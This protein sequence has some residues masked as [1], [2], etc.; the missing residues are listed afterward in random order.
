[1]GIFSRRRERARD[2]PRHTAPG[3]L[4]YMGGRLADWQANRSESI[5][6]AGARLANTLASAP[7][8]LYKKAL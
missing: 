5:C 3:E 6:A 4:H 8:H 1:M 2:E 7:L